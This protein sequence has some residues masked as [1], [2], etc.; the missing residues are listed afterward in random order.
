VYFDTGDLIR[1]GNLGIPIK[2][3]PAWALLA[4][5]RCTAGVLGNRETHVLESA[6][7]AKLQGAGHPLLCGNLRKRDGSRPLPSSIE[8]DVGGYRVGLIGVMVPMVTERM[9]T[10][11]ASAYIWEAPIPRAADLAREL[12]PRVDA[13]FA[14]THI[15]HRQDLELAAAVPELD[16]IFGGHSHTVAQEP[17]RVGR[18]AVAQGGSHAR[19][20]GVYEWTPESG[21]TGRLEP[22]R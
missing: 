15:G 13:L 17:V 2:S 20:A 22:L 7:K 1:T 5:L 16:A 19:F 4:E 12:R 3:D 21:L 14:L 6:F 8:L 10:S 18:T 11:I 9:K